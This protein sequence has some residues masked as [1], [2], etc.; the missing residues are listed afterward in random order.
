MYYIIKHPQVFE[1]IR[2]EVESVY[3]GSTN[4]QITFES[5]NKLRYIDAVINEVLRLSS[6]IPLSSR[7]TTVKDV[8]IGGIK[9]EANTVVYTNLKG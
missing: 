8:E 9:M 4:P 7:T 1:K 5:F 3:G 6:P 2:K